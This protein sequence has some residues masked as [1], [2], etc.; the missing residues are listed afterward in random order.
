MNSKLRTINR[1]FRA[2]SPAMLLACV[3][4]A[5]TALADEQVRTETVKFQDL[6]VDT[7]AGVETLYRRIHSAAGRVCSSNDPLEQLGAAACAK[8]AE[9][10]AIEKV[11]Q[12]SLTAF[13][14]MKT[15]DQRG[16]LTA[17]R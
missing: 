6:N 13:Y 4:V 9:A 15:G 14:R 5:S 2:H 10:K 11:N 8:K 12:P 7:P 16:M 3:L 17:K 1:T